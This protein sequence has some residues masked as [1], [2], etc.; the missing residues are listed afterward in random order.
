MQSHSL[1][2]KS[3]FSLPSLVMC[4]IVSLFQDQNTAIQSKA[5]KQYFP[6]VWSILLNKV[7]LT[8][9][10]VDVLGGSNF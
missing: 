5:V 2:A 7:V 3:F 1:F 10:P 8:F 6:V 4:S 9:E